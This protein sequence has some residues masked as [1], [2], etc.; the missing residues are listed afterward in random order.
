LKREGKRDVKP[1]SVEVFQREDG[2]VIVYQFP[3]SAEISKRDMLLRFE[4]HIG[5]VGVDYTFDLSQ[6][7]F[8]GKLEL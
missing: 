1:V 8:M 4:A 3:S 6:M 2:L 7:E 5:R